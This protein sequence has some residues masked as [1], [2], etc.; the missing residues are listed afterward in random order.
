M[1]A[2][3]QKGFL[4]ASP[5][6]IAPG[7]VRAIEGSSDVVYLPWFWRWIMLIVRLIPERVFKRLAF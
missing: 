1:T 6:K 5:E 2:R 3:F 4:W 7:I